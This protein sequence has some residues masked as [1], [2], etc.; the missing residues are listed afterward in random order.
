MH[1]IAALAAALALAVSAGAAHAG[2]HRHH[3]HRGPVLASH[4][5]SVGVASTYGRGDGTAGKPT[6]S[7]ERFRPGGLTA[8]HPSLPM[9]S[10]VRVTHLGNGRSVVVRIND[11]GPSRWTHRIID[12]STAAA[13]AIRLGGLGR[14]RVER[15]S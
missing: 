2:A 15:L 14:V 1:R 10:R 5:P 12:L 9:G 13:A 11:R 4:V 6:A 8:A 7:G 3:H